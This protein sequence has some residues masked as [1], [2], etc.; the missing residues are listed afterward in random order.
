MD[1]ADVVGR[2]KET[3]ELDGSCEW[4]SGPENVVERLVRL[5]VGE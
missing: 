1:D 2:P 5:V 4:Y 3:L